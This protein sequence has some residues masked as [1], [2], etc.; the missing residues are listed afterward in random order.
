MNGIKAHLRRYR[1]EIPSLCHRGILQGVQRRPGGPSAES[2]PASPLGF[3]IP[4]PCPWAIHLCCLGPQVTRSL[5][6]PELGQS[7][8][9]NKECRSLGEE[10]KL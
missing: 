10:G 9:E 2:G 7:G 5:L 8:M 3:D 6:Q 1:R 4:A